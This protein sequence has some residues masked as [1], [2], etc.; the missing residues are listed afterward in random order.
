MTHLSPGNQCRFASLCLAS[1]FASLLLLSSHLLPTH[2]PKNILA[3]RRNLILRQPD[4][5]LATRE[6]F[7]PPLP[8][9]HFLHVF[10]IPNPKFSF[11]QEE[12][13][14]TLLYLMPVACP[15]ASSGQE[16]CLVS[17]LCSVMLSFSLKM[18]KMEIGVPLIRRIWKTFDR[19]KVPV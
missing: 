6:E 16:F 10:Q 14:L 2:T 15:S 3:S 4:V 7:F 1:P 18:G 5:K 9:L 19:E 17:F 12:R 11:K 8:D 13:K